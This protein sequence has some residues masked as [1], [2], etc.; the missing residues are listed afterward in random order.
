MPAGTSIILMIIYTIV[1]CLSV[2]LGIIIGCFLIEPEDAN[3]AYIRIE[4]FVNRFYTYAARLCCLLKQNRLILCISRCLCHFIHMLQ[5]IGATLYKYRHEIKFGVVKIATWIKEQANGEDL[6]KYMSDV[7]LILSAEELNNLQDKLN[8]HPYD[9]PVLLSYES[10]SDGTVR[11]T[12]E[13][14]GLAEKYKGMEGVEL[15]KIPQFT[16]CNYI[17]ATRYRQV[18]VCILEATPT[19]LCFA[20]PISEYGKEK[21]QKL[22]Q[23]K[24]LMNQ[25][26]PVSLLEDAVTGDYCRLKK[27]L[28]LG[29]LLLDYN[30]CGLKIPLLINLS[31]QSSNVLIA[32]KSG[33]GKSQSMRLYIWNMLHSGENLC[34]IADY[35]GG[36]EYESFEGSSSYASGEN[37]IRMIED[38]YEFFTSVRSNR[39]RL[40]NHYTL[41]IEEWFGLLT[42]AEMQSKKLK[43]ELMAKVGELLA[44]CR[45][46]NMGIILCVQRADAALFPLGSREQF[47]CVLAFGR[48]SIE[49]FRMLG[50]SG[51]LED[52]PSH[53]YKAGQAMALIDG[54]EGVQ[55][56]VM[57]F[58]EKSDIVCQGIRAY[59]DKQPDIPTLTR[60]AAEGKSEGL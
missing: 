54:Q 38:F 32:G 23:E 34:F 43:A 14:L 3:K 29:Y 26:K 36:E 50:F 49:Q 31:K 52:N 42:Y 45:G 57:P 7:S 33:S 9:T 28:T 19:R 4:H 1:L 44:V 51:E 5:W 12:F 24:N 27:A 59:L 13:A 56:I 2:L 20:I 8:G 21:L 60:A 22:Y 40:Q 53:D 11:Y 15:G 37:A 46:L 16:I 10:P 48:T 47:Q 30:K 6:Y 55:E 41:L 17:M 39:I 35:K 18:P 58:I 25:R